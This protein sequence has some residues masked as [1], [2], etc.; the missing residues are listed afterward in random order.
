SIYPNGFSPFPSKPHPKIN[1]ESKEEMMSILLSQLI[2]SP[3][4]ERRQLLLQK[5][6]TKGPGASE[7]LKVPLLP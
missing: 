1:P 6:E 7:S 4:P 3:L 2:S 5:E